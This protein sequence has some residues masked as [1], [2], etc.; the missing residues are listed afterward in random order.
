LVNRNDGLGF[1]IQAAIVRKSCWPSRLGRSFTR[2]IPPFELSRT[3]DAAEFFREMSDGP[4]ASSALGV[5]LITESRLAT[6]LA[7]RIYLALSLDG[8][9]KCPLRDPSF[10]SWSGF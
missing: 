3:S 1:A 8:H 10:A 7:S 5:L 6:D 9:S 2:T 4:C